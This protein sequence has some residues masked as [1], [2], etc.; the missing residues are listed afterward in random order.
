MISDYELIYLIKDNNETALN[1]LYKRYYYVIIKVIKEYNVQPKHWDDYI[2]EGYISLGKCLK[3]Y[4]DRIECN[5]NTFFKLVLKRDFIKLYKK[6]NFYT[7]DLDTQYIEIKDNNIEYNA[8]LNDVY[9][10]GLELIN[11]VELRLIYISTY[12]EGLTPREISQKYGF[13]IKRIYND[14][15]FIKKELNKGF[16]S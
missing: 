15:Q 5:F 2:Q 13:N 10:K 16:N 6:Y 7:I 8:Y 11:D 9:K 3:K 1:L 12:K 4:D 14:I